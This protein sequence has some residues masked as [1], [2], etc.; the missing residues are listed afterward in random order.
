[1]EKIKL[2]DTTL[3]DGMQAEGVSFSLE[4]KL[5]IAKRLDQLGLDYIEGGYT[6]SNPKEM[7]FFAEVA[8][9]GLSNSKIVAFGSTRRA[10]SKVS[11]DVSLNAIIACKTPAAALVGKSW[12]LHVTDVLACSLDEN[13]SMCAESVRFLKKHGI[14]T[15]FDAEHFYDGYRKN[16]E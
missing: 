9:L 10:H 1:M 15:I 2:Y 8:K 4:D 5:L 3:R 16:P 6:A 11:D 7:K 13:L 14:E 12:D